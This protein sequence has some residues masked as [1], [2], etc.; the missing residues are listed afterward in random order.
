M[1]GF[2]NR[3]TLVGHSIKAANFSEHYEPETQQKIP[4]V[5]VGSGRTGLKV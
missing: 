4:C 5:G 3:L 1:R 2:L